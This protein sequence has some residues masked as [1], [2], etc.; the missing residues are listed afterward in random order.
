MQ[1][2]LSPTSAISGAN[3]KAALISDGRF[4]GGTRGLCVGHISPEAAS[5]GEVGLI[6]N[7]DLIE[8]DVKEKKIQLKVSDEELAERKKK[9]KRFRSRVKG[10]WLARY[11]RF[12]QSADKGA[13]LSLPDE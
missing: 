11:A 2:M 3:I 6:K 8:I 10:G 12:V 1:E 4:S 7:G 13:V 5:G 9:M